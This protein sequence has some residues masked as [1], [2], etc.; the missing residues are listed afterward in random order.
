MPG[1][2]RVAVVDDH[3]LFREGVTNTLAASADIDVV[4]QG[5]TAEEAVCLARDL[6]PDIVLL[7]ISMSGGGINAAQEISAAYPAVKI[8]MLTVSESEDDLIGSLKAGARGY[9]LK[10]VSAGDLRRIISSIQAGE[11]YVTPSLAASLLREWPDRSDGAC[12]PGG[13]LDDLTPRERQV[14]EL[15][16][17]GRNNKE[18]AR[19]LNL[20]VKT[21]KHYM[22][23]I[24]QKLHVRNRVEAALLAQKVANRQA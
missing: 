13:P 1:K 5:E 20:S 11:A 7:D 15:L 24:L 9:I 6:M 18:I 16:A 12:A 2:I 3:P 17:T 23:N 21:V 22:T 4:G 19:E 8:I 10:G 14:L